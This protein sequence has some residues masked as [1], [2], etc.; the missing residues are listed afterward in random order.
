MTVDTPGTVVYR[1][2]QENWFVN[3][4]RIGWHPSFPTYVDVLPGQSGRAATCRRVDIG[5][6]RT[7]A[8]VG[9][10]ASPA[11]PSRRRPCA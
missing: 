5:A 6:E 7:G 1:V 8:A 2:R 10:G 11:P 4:N 9:S 3:G